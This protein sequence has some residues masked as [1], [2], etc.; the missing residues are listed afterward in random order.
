MEIIYLW[1]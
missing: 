1:T